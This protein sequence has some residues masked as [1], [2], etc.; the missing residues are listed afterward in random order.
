[1]RPPEAAFTATRGGLRRN[2]QRLGPVALTALTATR[3][4]LRRNKQRL[5][6]EIKGGEFWDR[7][8]YGF[9]IGFHES[10]LFV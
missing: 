3:G 1:M 10:R 4:G 8:P 6:E 5:G 9:L 7:L 2:K